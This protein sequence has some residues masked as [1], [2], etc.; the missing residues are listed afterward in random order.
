[1]R[2]SVIAIIIIV[3]VVLYMSVFVVK[4]GER[5]ITLRFG[6]VLRDDDNKP[7][8]YEPGLHFKIPF[9]ETVKMLDARIQTMDNQ[10]DRF[11]TKEKKDLIV[12]SYIK[13][14]ISDFSRYYLATGGG[15]ISQAEVLLKRKFSDRLR[16][17]IGRLDV[18]DIV[19]DSRGR[20]TLEVRD[21]LCRFGNGVICCRGSNFIF[22][23]RRT[24]VQRV[25]YFEGQTTTRIGDD[26][27]HVQA[28]NF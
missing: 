24:G 26:V 12:D 13:W 19:T 11:V 15:D 17:E 6:K 5:G 28:T 23:T 1:M 18:K 10:A 27:F 14:R 3:L 8:V 4:E 20:L 21:A 16:S 2:K 7:L 9:I 22:C 25:T